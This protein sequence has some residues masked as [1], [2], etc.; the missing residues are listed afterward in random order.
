M[1]YTGDVTIVTETYRLRP[2]IK[3]P[4]DSRRTTLEVSEK[5]QVL[6]GSVLE[7]EKLQF[8]TLPKKVNTTEVPVV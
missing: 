4:R 3:A 1:L 8:L 6:S 5:V 7:Q 2:Q